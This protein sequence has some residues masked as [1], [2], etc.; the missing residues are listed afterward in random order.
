[1]Y[2]PNVET[3]IKGAVKDIL[4]HVTVVLLFVST[5]VC[6]FFQNSIIQKIV[7]ENY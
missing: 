5:L 1:M 4:K 3:L 6:L 2:T 7:P